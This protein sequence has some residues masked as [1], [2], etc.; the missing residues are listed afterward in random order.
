MLFGCLGDG[1]TDIA[2]LNK[3]PDIYLGEKVVL[4]GNVT[5][6]VKLGKISGF[7][8]VN[9]DGSIPVSSQLLPPDWREV[10]IKGTLMKEMLAGYYVLVDELDMT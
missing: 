2:D 5:K 1:L 8:L 9:K 3:N 10:I 4:K 6:S 7:T